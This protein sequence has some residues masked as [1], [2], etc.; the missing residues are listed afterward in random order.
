MRRSKASGLSAPVSPADLEVELRLEPKGMRIILVGGFR[1]GED[2]WKF[3]RT[4]RAPADLVPQ[5]VGSTTSQKNLEVITP[6][7]VSYHALGFGGNGTLMRQVHLQAFLE[8]G[9][10]VADVQKHD[11]VV[12]GKEHSPIPISQC[13]GIAH[14][15]H[16]PRGAD[17]GVEQ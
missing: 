13:K 9:Y 11:I 10:P 6:D 4:V 14:N 5:L 12:L 2:M 3:V 7:G 17:T 8:A 16:P 15:I 1:T